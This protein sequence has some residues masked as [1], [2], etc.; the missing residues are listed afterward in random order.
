MSKKH[1]HVQ[2]FMQK[3]STKAPGT[4]AEERALFESYGTSPETI[5]QDMHRQ[6]YDVQRIAKSMRS[7]GAALQ[8]TAEQTQTQQLHEVLNTPAPYFE[9]VVTAGP[10]S[11][12]LSDQARLS[13][14]ANLLGDLPIQDA[15][16]VNVK[17]DSM[18]DI[19]IVEGDVL[20]VNTKAK[21]KSGDVV[22]ALVEE[23]GQ[24]VK[25][26]ELKADE[27]WLHSE[28]TAYSPIHITTAASLQIQGVVWGRL[29][30]I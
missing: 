5:T 15:I 16:F 12:A 3:L 29:G 11:P 6:G 9:E 4:S 7:V 17:G 8:D 30:K 14:L 20:I 23:L 2:E 13:T 18:K 26:L 24:L 22:V 28:N 27:A 19:G 10:A 25:R 21:A 1:P